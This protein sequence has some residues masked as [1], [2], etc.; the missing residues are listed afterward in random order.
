MFSENKDFRWECRN[1]LIEKLCGC[2]AAS[3]PKVGAVNESICSMAIYSET[4]CLK[5]SISDDSI[6]IQSCLQPCERWKFDCQK[7]EEEASSIWSHNDDSSKWATIQ[8]TVLDFDY[9]VFEEQ[10]LWT[11]ENFIGSFGGVLALFLGLDVTVLIPMF[12]YIAAIF[13]NIV[14]AIRQARKKKLEF[15][16][17]RDGNLRNVVVVPK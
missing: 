4:G 3:L 15:I 7:I 17:S 8:L 10:Y 6:C 9:D 12:I 11:L 14:S 16:N 13:Y 1:K 2:N 5:Y